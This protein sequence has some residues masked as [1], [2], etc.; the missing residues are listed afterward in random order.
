[1]ILIDVPVSSAV[2][3]LCTSNPIHAASMASISSIS[4][5]APETQTVPTIMVV[6]T[7]MM[8]TAK[9]SRMMMQTET[10]VMVVFITATPSLSDASISAI[11][12]S[13]A[14]VKHQV[15]GVLAASYVFLLH[16][17]NGN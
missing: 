8:I 11:S 4:G 13:N 6:P 16:K 10:S 1:M 15:A 17:C 12:S 9:V 2:M 3:S 5:I 7:T 14:S